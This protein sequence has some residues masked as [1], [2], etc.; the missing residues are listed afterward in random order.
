[1]ARP[2][3]VPFTTSV[4]RQ[5]EQGAVVI[6]LHE[7]ERLRKRFGDLERAMNDTTALVEAIGEQQVNSAKR[8]IGETKRSPS[9]KP[10]KPWSESYR[11]TR[12]PQ[13]SLLVNEGHLLSSLT[14]EPVSPGEVLVGSPLEYAGVH[15]FG[16]KDG[17][18][19]ARPYLDTTG[20]FADS[21]DRR[22]L[23]DVIRDFWKQEVGR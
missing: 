6:G 18:T 12:E 19:P 8:R 11:K 23:R 2:P 4:A 10:W 5:A 16:S 15:L 13:H 20:G 1:M 14:Y 9:G 7:M 17:R 3:K 22:E 21:A